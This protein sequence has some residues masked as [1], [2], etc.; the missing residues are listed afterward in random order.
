LAWFSGITRI[1]LDLVSTSLVQKKHFEDL[2]SPFP[3]CSLF[4]K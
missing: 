2:S 3:K 4:S 1:V